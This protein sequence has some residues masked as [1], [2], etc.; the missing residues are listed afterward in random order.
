MTRTR[1]SRRA[2]G[3]LAA[4]AV[5]VAGTVAPSAAIDGDTLT[6]AGPATGTVNTPVVLT[7]SGVLA[8]H[9]LD[10]W[11]E[12]FALPT[13]VVSSCPA[14]VMNA[15]TVAAG[16]STIGG[17]LVATAVHAGNAQPYSIA[18]V[19][20]PRV[21]GTYLICTYL[22]HQIYTDVL[23]QHSIKVSGPVATPPPPVVTPAPPVVTPPGT[24]SAPVRIT[25]PRLVRR[26]PRLVCSRGT[27]SGSPTSY[28]FAWKVGKRITG[29]T[30][31]RLRV[32]RSLRGRTVSCG[33]VAANAAGSSTAWSRRIRVR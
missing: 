24:V 10:R 16:S 32:T 3:V 28:A 21:P 12:V 27:W 19:W 18:I 29:A 2:A 26:G 23:H 14:S 6:V 11:L 4:A 9:Y 25:A 13:A 5:V 7:A 17:D 30:S 15:P 33:V 1:T 22:N 31:S 20:S 8:D